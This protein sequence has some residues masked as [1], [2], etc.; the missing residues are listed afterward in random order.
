MF[1]RITPGLKH[2]ERSGGTVH[3]EPLLIYKY[4][5]RSTVKPINDVEHATFFLSFDF[6][7]FCGNTLM[8]HYPV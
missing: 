3:L 2:Y 4:R 1:P 7:N 6:P 8:T 5:D